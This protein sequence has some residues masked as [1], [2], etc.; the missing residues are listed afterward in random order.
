LVPD[1]DVGVLL[2]RRVLLVVI[3][4]LTLLPLTASC[5]VLDEP[6]TRITIQFSDATGL[7]RGNDVGI[8]GVKVGHVESITPAGTPVDV[9]VVIGADVEL[10]RDVGAVIVSRS[11]ATDRYVELTPAYTAG[12]TLADGAVIG[13]DRTR[14][15]VEFEELLG[16]LEDLASSLGGPDGQKG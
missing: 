14:T 1:P 7:F 2:M 10:P 8:R 4:A 5:G 3:A 13:V 9:E 11:V 15:P 12:P 16:S 6:R